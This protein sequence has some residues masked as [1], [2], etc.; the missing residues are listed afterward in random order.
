MRDMVVGVPRWR[1]A[2]RDVAGTRA[3]GVVRRG[4]QTLHRDGAVSR[5]R[6]AVWRGG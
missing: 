1:A 5:D 2:R 3:G 6:S 4:S